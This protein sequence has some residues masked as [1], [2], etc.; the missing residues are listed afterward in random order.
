MKILQLRELLEEKYD[1]YNR[2]EFIESDPV[3][4]P[5]LFSRRNDIEIAGFLTATISWG[6]RK[7]I[8]VNAHR[9]MELMDMSPGQFVSGYAESDLVRF[10]SFVHRTFNAKDLRF[11]IRALRNLLQ[12]FKTL[13]NAFVPGKSKP[14]MAERISVFRERMLLAPHEK[15]T[16]KHLADPLSGSAAKR[17]CMFLR[18]M[19]RK[20]NRGVDF[21][22]WNK[23]RPAELM[24]PLDVHTGNVGR[25]L[26]LLGRKQNDWKAVEEVTFNLRKIDPDDPVRFDY[27]LFGMGISGNTPI[28][29]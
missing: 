7:S 4:I 12:K 15:R 14:S 26:G 20:D 6:N 18:W 10:S 2:P 25:S 17:I 3:S 24:L 5:H 27:A 1:L 21:G 13:E 11:F 29:S 9:M 8:L 19:V 16:M 28:L 22:I 23:I